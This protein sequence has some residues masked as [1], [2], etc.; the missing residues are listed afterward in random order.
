[1]RK[2][3][4]AALVAASLLACGNDAIKLATTI[5]PKASCESTNNS[6]SSDDRDR[7][8][9]RSGRDV[10]ACTETDCHKI[11]DAVLEAK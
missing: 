6:W 4:L 10:W 1:M 11:A 3:F 7:A 5:D 9:C 2:I 8:I